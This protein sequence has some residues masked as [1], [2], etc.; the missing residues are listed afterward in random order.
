M[1]KKDAV[2]HFGSQ[3]KVARALGIGKAAVGKWGQVVPPF[4]A[5]RLQELSGGVLRYDTADYVGWY[6]RNREAA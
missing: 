1:L 4:Q 5:S 2:A 6:S 3:T